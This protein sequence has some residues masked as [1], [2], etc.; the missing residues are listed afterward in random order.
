MANKTIKV[1]VDVILS[2]IFFIVASILVNWIAGMIFGYD[3]GGNANMNGGV[4]LA[5][6]VFL[7]LGFAIWFY[8]FVH[9][10]KS[11]NK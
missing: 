4:L 10:G 11:G 3:D 2:F 1:V 9:L 8:K 5:I 7:T 6:T